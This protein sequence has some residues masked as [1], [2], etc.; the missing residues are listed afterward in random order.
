VHAFFAADTPLLT[1]GE[2]SGCAQ[3]LLSGAGLAGVVHPEALLGAADRL[4][5]FVKG[6]WG[7]AMWHREVPVEALIDAAAGR[8]RVS[9]TIDLLLE[10]TK[11]YVLIDHKTFPGRGELAVRKKVQEFLPQLAAYAAALRQVPGAKLAE[12]WVHFPVSGAMVELGV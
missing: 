10:T 3:R 5:A 9:G 1:T 12:C 11:G 4:L 2:R 6:R 8:R 7:D